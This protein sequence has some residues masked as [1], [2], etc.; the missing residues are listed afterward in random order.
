MKK[1][2]L[3]SGLSGN[4]SGSGKGSTA[5]SDIPC[6]KCGKNGH[7]QKDCRSKGNGSSGN[8]PKKP[9]NELPEWVTRNPV[10]LDTKDPTT[11]NTA[12]NNKKWCTS[13]NNG[14]GACGFHWKDGHEEWKI[15]QGKKP[16]VCFSNPATNTVIYCSYLMTTS[17]ESTEKEEKGGYDSQNNDFISLSR[18]ELLE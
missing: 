6:H 17:E 7:I 15:K 3:K 8:P 9:T 14:Q 5:R 13:C 16:S 2:D 1:V 12:R 11:A 10:V 4:G 18:F